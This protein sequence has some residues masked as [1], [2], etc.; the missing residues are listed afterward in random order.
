MVV[1][2]KSTSDAKAAQ[3]FP[4]DPNSRLSTIDT[5]VREIAEVGGDAAA[6]PVDVR[7]FGSIQRLMDETIK[8]STV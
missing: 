5:V 3:P 7:D 2:A 4:P 1:A 8:V 6:I